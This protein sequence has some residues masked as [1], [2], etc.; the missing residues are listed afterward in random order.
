MDRFNRL[1][2]SAAQ[3]RPYNRASGRRNWTAARSH[4][5]FIL[6]HGR[7]WRTIHRHIIWLNVKLSNFTLGP[8]V[9]NDAKEPG[10]FF[11]ATSCWWANSANEGGTFRPLRRAFCRPG[12]PVLDR[13]S[14]GLP[15]RWHLRLL[16]L[17]LMLIRIIVGWFLSVE[18]QRHGYESGGRSGFYKC[19]RNED[20]RMM[21]SDMEDRDQIRY[22]R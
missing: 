16:N 6:D 4:V 9:T 22:G 10:W 13:P 2:S 11:L 21:R 14:A 1:V 18:H 7:A 3:R 8:I 15:S 19:A 12:H 5:S 17:L 20:R